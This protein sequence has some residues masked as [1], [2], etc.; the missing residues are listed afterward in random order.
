MR[1]RPSPRSGAADP[2]VPALPPVV[3]IGASRGGI[4]ALRTVLSGLPNVTT[5]FRDPE[6]WEVL[7]RD[8]LPRIV[9]G[10]ADG[11][12]IRFEPV[13]AGYAFRT[14]LRRQVIFGRHDLV[15]VAPISHL[16]LLVSR[17]TLMHFDGDTQTGS[18]SRWATG[19]CS[20]RARP[21]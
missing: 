6:A 2:A 13:A 21:R 11:A 19:A 3:A 18:T 1:S 16:D 15:R 20:S 7:T 14:D 17:S 5:F 12:P 8:H 9:A 10:K 4:E